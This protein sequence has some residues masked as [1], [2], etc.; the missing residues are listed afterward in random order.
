MTSYGGDSIILD[1][2]GDSSPMIPLSSNTGKG[3][4]AQAQI[5][6]PSRK[7]GSTGGSRVSFGNGSRLT[8]QLE[9][10][11]DNDDNDAGSDRVAGGINITKRRASP[12]S[13][14]ATPVVANYRTFVH[15]ALC[16]DGIFVAT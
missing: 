10:I 3:S 16:P 1:V 14:F 6:S 13:P 11:D 2:D 5:V 8:S 15:A 12:A 7:T 4:K 9:D